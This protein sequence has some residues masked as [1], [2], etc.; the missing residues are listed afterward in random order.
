MIRV[1]LVVDVPFYRDGL[2]RLL[3]QDADIAVIGAVAGGDAVATARREQPD[4]VLLDI[5]S[6]GARTWIAQVCNLSQPP[7][8]VALAVDDAEESIV[9][10]I[11]AGISG[12][13]SRNSSYVELL[14]VL[15]AAVR[16]EW[17]CS[18]R[19][20][21]L[22]IRRLSALSAG[23]RSASASAASLTVRER[24]ILELIGK[25]LSNK[26]IAVALRISHATAKNHVHHILGK[27]RLENRAAVAAYLNGA[28]RA[29]PI[30]SEARS[31]PLEVS[32]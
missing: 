4:L 24:Q 7:R 8:V 2:Y 28:T 6:P 5:S 21:S 12:Y 18:P 17:S 32:Q 30:A 16:G 13:V 22:V 15:H 10:W 11:E 23:A 3:S 25:G 31:A 26:R 27:L 14:Q 1:L 20:M 19:V 9:R 29:P